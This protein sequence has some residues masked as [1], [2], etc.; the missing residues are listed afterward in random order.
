MAS[1]VSAIRTDKPPIQKAF[2]AFQTRKGVS[3]KLDDRFHRQLGI[4]QLR[5]WKL[6]T[7]RAQPRPNELK[8]LSTFLECDIRDLI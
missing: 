8:A 2:E 4:A 5:F 6:R 1:V 3:V 7:G